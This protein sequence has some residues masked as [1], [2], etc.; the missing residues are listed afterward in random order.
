MTTLLRKRHAGG[1]SPTWR[2]RT[3]RGGVVGSVLGAVILAALTA[4]T[5][6]TP[7]GPNSTTP[8]GNATSSAAGG[9][10]ATGTDL[11]PPD[12]DAAA[13]GAPTGAADSSAQPA[14]PPAAALLH[15]LDGASTA[16]GVVT[17]SAPL[18]KWVGRAPGESATLGDG[19]YRYF[20]P[21]G[22]LVGCTSGGACVGVG[23]DGTVAVTRAP[24]QPREVYRPDG[25]YLGRYGA[26]GGELGADTDPAKLS[27]ALAGTG[28]D[29]A[30]LV[31]A[32][33]RRV[34]FAGGVTGDPHLITMGGQ[35]YTTQAA[36]QFVAR[37]GDSQHEIDLQFSPMAHRADVSIV[38]MIAIGAGRDV[39]RMDATGALIVNG[40]NLLH[41]AGF[42]QTALSGGV[43]VGRWPAH[44]AN[45]VTVAVVWPDGGTVVASADRA[46]GIT[47]VAHLPPAAHATG[48]FGTSAV[49]SGPDLTMP[50]GNS[51]SAA[52]GI[53]AEVAAWRVPQPGHL[54]PTATAPQSGIASK[55][56][57]VDPA[58]EKVAER[59]CGGHGMSQSQ[60]VAA[61]AFDIAVTGDTGFIPGHI[62]LARA[63]Q[64]TG[65]PMSFAQRWPALEAGP[66]AAATSLPD[67]GLVAISIAPAG[68]QLYRL[69]TTASGLVRVASS[70]SCSPSSSKVAVEPEMNQPSWR[71]FDDMGRPVSDRM[72]LCGTGVTGIV[73]VGDYLLAIANG[74]N[75]PTLHVNSTV[76]LP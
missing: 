27:A 65:V 47:M 57:D 70:E 75:E 6:T 26:D 73:P 76:T 37:T 3:A 33:S 68:A 66:T 74:V 32:A 41:A 38:S 34:P 54:L 67:G 31:N 20:G 40:E 7:V 28:V 4:C 71:L 51:V 48:L 58:A 44:E 53:E 59:L 13:A 1:T 43:A 63:A 23:Q 30:G 8:L 72:A 21:D 52:G 24:D 42:T 10:A 12:T 56:V 15:W 9:A 36:G 29:L 35:R 60:D 11:I 18:Q 64:S 46:L 5:A 25:T 62:A 14:G 2:N 19:W 39:I 22:S 49:S 61:C 69:A 16:D 45:P 50:G 55:P 17:G